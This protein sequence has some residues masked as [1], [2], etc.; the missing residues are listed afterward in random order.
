[1]DP[2]TLGTYSDAVLVRHLLGSYGVAIHRNFGWAQLTARAIAMPHEEGIAIE[3]QPGESGMDTLASPRPTSHHSTCCWHSKHVNPAP[4][5][6]VP[7]WTQLLGQEAHHN[8]LLASIP[9]YN[10]GSM[11]HLIWHFALCW[12]WYIR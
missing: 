11:A 1:M 5:S 2:I 3:T 9:A 8:V 7:T 4:W 6:H 10:T 12:S